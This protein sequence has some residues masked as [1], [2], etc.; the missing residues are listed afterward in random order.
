MAGGATFEGAA[1]EP[2]PGRAAYP[3]ARNLRTR[4]WLTFFGIRVDRRNRAPRTPDARRVD[5]Y[6]KK[7]TREDICL[8]HRKNRSNWQRT[9]DN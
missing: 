6:H 8:I 7:E 3:C 1:G 4:D 9:L 2:C 5:R